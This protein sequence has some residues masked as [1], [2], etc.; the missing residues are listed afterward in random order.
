MPN[1]YHP[2]IEIVDY[3]NDA[4]S[5][6]LADIQAFARNGRDCDTRIVSCDHQLADADGVL[7]AY[8]VPPNYMVTDTELG[9]AVAGLL[10]DELADDQS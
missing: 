8:R 4:M 6:D 5:L 3:I 9:E 10:D 1:P 2:I 7:V